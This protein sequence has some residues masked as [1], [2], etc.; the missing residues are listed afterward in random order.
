M[1]MHYRYQ[2]LGKSGRLVEGKASAADVL[3][4]RLELE[5]A[6]LTLVDARPDALAILSSAMVS[7]TLKTSVL[8]DI[9]GFL[10]G[11]LAM[12]IDMV[13]AWNSVGESLTYPNAKEACAAIQRAI[14]SGYTLA[15]AMERTGVFPPL[16]IGNVRAGETAG[17]LESVFA[18]LEETFR[19]QQALR[20][21]VYKATLYPLISLVVLFF[22]AVGLL[23]GVVPQLK[24]IFPPNPPLPTKILVFLSESVVGYWWV[25][26]L[27]VLGGV[28]TWWK[29]P[30]AAKTRVWETVYKL[31]LMGSPL[32]NVLLSNVF[33][34]LAL[35]LESGLTLL[36]ALRIAAQ[37]STS[38]AMKVR[39][40]DTL[41]K[42]EKGG[43]FSD[44]FRDDF[45]PSMTAGVLAQGELTG[46]ISTYLRR[47]S[48]FL[49]DRA[50]ARLLALSVLLEPLML[51][52]GGGML[53][54][55]AVGIFLP[56]YGAMKHIGH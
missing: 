34:N 45:F 39:L 31:P 47:M 17:R 1:A 16:V 53:M 23:A 51:L 14:R 2:A 43:K 4:L 25:L 41:E 8:I 42:I 13:S 52:L 27:V 18:A 24:E 50:Q 36:L 38:L 46:S 12:G 37:T 3:S 20:S 26:P 33:D 5:G 30:E 55:L 44:G 22:I 21:Q 32:K 56:I 7:K 29:L 49:R 35:M 54:L 28:A 6:G 10:R 11:L 15:D 9:F 40:E 19:Q 48:N